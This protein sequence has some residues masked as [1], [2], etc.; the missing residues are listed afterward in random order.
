MSIEHLVNDRK[1][2]NQ[3]PQS[4]PI[5]G[6]VPNSAG[7]Y[8]FLLDDW[9]RLDRF[10]ILGT[11]GGTYYVS[12]KKLTKDNAGVVERCFKE[13]PARTA[14]RIVEVS[15]GGLAPSNDPAI[16]ALAIGVAC[17]PGAR[18]AA[19]AALPAVCRIGTHLFHFMAF[20]DGAGSGRSVQRALQEWYLKRPANRLVEQLVKY[21]SRDGWSHR[22]V[23]RLAKPATPPL[24]AQDLA[25]CWAARGDEKYLEKRAAMAIPPTD[26]A[27]IDAFISIKDSKDKKAIIK[28][29]TEARLPRECVPTAALKH[30][31]VWEALLPHMGLTALIRNLGNLSK[32][33]LLKA[34]SQV[35]KEV[36]ARLRSVEELQK[37]RIHPY[38]V[39]L[40]L[41]TYAAGQGFRGKGDWVP[42]PTVV[43]ALDDAFYAAFKFI[44]PTGK[45]LYLGIDVSGSMSGP[46]A[47]SHVSVRQG[48]AAM[49]MATARTE[50][51][52]EYEIRGFTD[53]M[54][55]L[56]ITAKDTL[57][58]ATKKADRDF[59]ATDCA[60]PMLDA[61]KRGVDVDAFV[62]YTD[63]ETW[64]GAI[65]P[66]QALAQ[67]RKKTGIP[68]KLIVVGM[69]STGFTV[70]DPKDPS[71]LDVVGFDASTPAVLSNFIAERELQS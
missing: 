43:D 44:E 64:A 6:T 26:L 59:C 14:A 39:L 25:L 68:A 70:A 56:G 20:A 33:E 36:Q 2:V 8:A 41:T 55:S 67:Y 57:G 22:D 16:F 45:R 30:P 10:L 1:S 13:N 4:E 71:M 32:C 52:G 65:H 34:N 23:L 40:A 27:M 58:S 28:A 69:T 29:I 7:G 35:A 15:K 51:D 50:K 3:T 61:M 47:N 66:V 12:E 38:G 21:Q 19:L 54:V 46:I 9:K 60:L 49:A 24:T 31:E 17:G 11:E 48:A 42:V 18:A 5:P 62:I 37:A 63:N 53:R